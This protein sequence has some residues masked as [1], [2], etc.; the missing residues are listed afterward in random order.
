[1]KKTYLGGWPIALFNEF[2]DFFQVAL[3]ILG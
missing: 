2:N 1:L 3:V